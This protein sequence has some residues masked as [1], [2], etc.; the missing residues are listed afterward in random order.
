MKKEETLK[1][2]AEIKSF[3]DV[4]KDVEDKINSELEQGWYKS[5]GYKDMNLT[6]TSESSALKS[7]Y[8]VMK[9]KLDKIILC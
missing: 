1:V 4:V 5:K 6:G 9:Y 2:R 3:L 8:K 7:A